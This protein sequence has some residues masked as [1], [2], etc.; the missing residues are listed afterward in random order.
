MKREKWK[1][2]VLDDDPTGIQTVHGCL[3]ITQWDEESVRLGFA[4]E[5]PFFYILTNTRA[6]TREEAAR[7]TREA[8]EMVVKVNEDYGYRLV[9][10]SRSDSCLRG[11]FPL[12]TDVMRECFTGRGLSVLP[13]TPFCPAFIESGRVTIKGVHYMKDGE[14]MIPVSETEFARDNVF[15]YHTSVLHDYILEKGADPDDYIIVNAQSYEELNASASQIVSSVLA[16]DSSII[17]RSSSSLPKAIAGCPDI[18][19]LDGSMLK[20]A[21][22][23]CFIVGSHVKKTTR[24]LEALLCESGTFGVELDVRRILEDSEPLMQ[25][26]LAVM[27]QVA[28]QGLVP[29][30]YTSRQEVRL[31]DA[32]LRQHL[33]QKVSDFLVDV[34]RRMPFTPAYLVA[35]GGITSHDIMTKGLGI[36]SA[37]VMGQ[38]V[39]SVPCVMTRDFPYVI[40]P[41]NVGDE[42]SLRET[43][44][45]LS[46]S[47]D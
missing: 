46:A 13:K 15:G 43:Y 3:L 24:Q 6:L 10:V 36:K 5:Q 9:I 47:Q 35:K 16:H 39:N 45:K 8:M 37:R 38:I 33:G 12:E 32:D 20:S 27:Q 4:D 2:V 25:E 30:V 41:G 11:H 26:T 21:G 22:V 31:D 23:G 42:N 44:Q 14:R 29:V 40:F 7:V 17:I 28:G 34:V 1:M 18:P 19:L